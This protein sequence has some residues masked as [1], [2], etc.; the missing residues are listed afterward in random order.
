MNN[1]LKGINS[2]ITKTEEWINNLEDNG[3]NKCCKTECRKKNEKNWDNLWD[4]WDNSKCTSIHII[5]IPEGEE[6]KD[7]R[8]IWR[9]NSWKIPNMGKEIVKQVQK[10]QRGS[11]RINP[12]R[13]T[14]RHIVIRLIKSNKGKKKTHTHTHTHT[15][16][17]KGNSI[18]L[19][20]DNRNSTSQN[21]MHDT[22]KVMKWK[23][24]QPTR[25]LYPTKLSLRFGG[26]IKSFPESRN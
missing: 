1:T 17:Y 18:S 2:R 6:R 20:T 4:L 5:V 10:V 12:S 22:C 21:G 24:L 3:G 19:S 7:L 13:N 16:I 11:C 8:N 23:N 15:N 26:K 9:D 14:L 25:M